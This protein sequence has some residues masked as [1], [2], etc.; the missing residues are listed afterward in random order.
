MHTISIEQITQDIEDL[1][2]L[3]AVVMNLLNQIDREDLD[4][5]DIAQQL[6]QDSALTAKTLRIANSAYYTTMVRVATVPQAIALLG[7][8]S[9]KNVV[10]SAALSGCFPD[11]RCRG[12]SHEAFWRHSNAVAIAAKI[13]AQR[14]KFNQDL[15]FTAGLLHDIGALVLVSSHTAQYEAIIA[16][17]EAELLTQAAAERE[18]L[19]IDHAQIGEALA[20]HWQFPD[21]IIKGIAGHHQP[22]KPGMGFLPTI[23]HVADAIAHTLNISST[24][25]LAPAEVTAQAWES[26][27]LD[28]DILEQVLVE[29]G[30]AFQKIN[31]NAA[32]EA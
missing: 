15:A 13:L 27:G 9:F 17:R 32:I 5:F 24:S 19:G 1:P 31:E 30:Q 3:P 29:A 16:H 7:I 10:L 12:F 18:L 11:R 2:S 6:T 23:V 21:A 4:I 14:L 22:D 25:D 20:R 28:H 8:H 26:L